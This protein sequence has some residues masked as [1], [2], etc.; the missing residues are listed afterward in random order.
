M[1]KTKKYAESVTI[2][3]EIFYVELSNYISIISRNFAPDYCKKQRT[4]AIANG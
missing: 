2:L 4:P 1:K 3:I